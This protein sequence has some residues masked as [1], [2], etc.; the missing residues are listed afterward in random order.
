MSYVDTEMERQD[1]GLTGLYKVTVKLQETMLTALVLTSYIKAL[2]H[3][4][5]MVHVSVIRNKI[6]TIYIG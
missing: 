2:A 3:T 4:L 6:F 5:Y 1:M